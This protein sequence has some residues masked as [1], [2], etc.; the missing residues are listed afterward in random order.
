MRIFFILQ[1]SLILCD[2]CL[3]CFCWQKKPYARNN[4]VQLNHQM[5]PWRPGNFNMPKPSD[6]SEPEKN[7]DSDD[8][9]LPT[10]N[11]HYDYKPTDWI[12]EGHKI[13]QTIEMQR[14]LELATEQY[15]LNAER[16]RKSILQ[17]KYILNELLQQLATM[18]SQNQK[19]IPKDL[20]IGSIA[21]DPLKMSKIKNDVVKEWKKYTPLS[22]K[23][24][25]LKGRQIE[26]SFELTNY[27]LYHFNNIY[28]HF[29]DQYTTS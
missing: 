13:N 17:R 2:L 23:T 16:L 4:F 12:A 20:L 15:Y 27:P 7:T 29:S 24:K 9:N 25:F 26:N 3:T 28:A 5:K 21:S 22:K 19:S 18:H 6:K 1:I 11:V 10:I 8:S 14:E